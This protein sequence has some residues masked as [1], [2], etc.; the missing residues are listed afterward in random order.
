MLGPVLMAG[1]TDGPNDVDADPHSIGDYISE[2][3]S[4]G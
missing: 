1:L 4:S 3:P 2:L